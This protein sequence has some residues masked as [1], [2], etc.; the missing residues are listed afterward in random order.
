MSE[1]TYSRTLLIDSSGVLHRCFHGYPDISNHWEGQNINVNA[2]FGYME[3]TK[4][5]MNEFACERI[6]HVLDPDGGS[7]YRYG[8][9][10]EYKANRDPTDPALKIQKDLLPK[11]LA[12]MGQ[13]YIQVPGVESDDVLGILAKKA[14]AQNHLVMIVS[15]DKDLLQIV[16]DGKIGLVRYVKRNDGADGKV[17]QYYDEGEVLKSL[18]VLPNQVAD[19]LALIGDS[20]DNIPGVKDC[21]PKTAATWLQTY[22]NLATLMMHAQE[23]KGRGAKGLVE[24]LDKLPLYQQLTTVLQDIEGVDFPEDRPHLAEE[25]DRFCSLLRAPYE[26]RTLFGPKGYVYEQQTSPAPRVQET[27][28]VEQPAAKPEWK[29]PS[30]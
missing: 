7:D 1:Q 3:Y 20:S 6:I 25:C 24:A 16:E 14:N 18:G 30:F 28:P 22:G 17:H 23:I 8:L 21:G 19:Y 26:W 9:Y 29:R 4:R 13:S 12:A 5:L 15:Q 2:L 10:P 11:L 27:T